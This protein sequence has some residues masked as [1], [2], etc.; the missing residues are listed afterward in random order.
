[1]MTELS[2]QSLMRIPT[3]PKWRSDRNDGVSVP[4]NNDPTVYRYNSWNE[5]HGSFVRN[6]F[7]ANR[8]AM[9][10]GNVLLWLMWIAPRF[11]DQAA[12]YHNGA[13]DM[14]FCSL[15]Y[16]CLSSRSFIFQSLLGT[17]SEVNTEYRYDQC[18]TGQGSSVNWIPLVPGVSWQVTSRWQ[19]IPVYI[20]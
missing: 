9:V 13:V 6:D 4:R 7:V 5:D 12:S 17:F 14:L 10:L 3:N 19:C 11:V 15:R 20:T 2:L 8:T 18:R 1:M 16:Y